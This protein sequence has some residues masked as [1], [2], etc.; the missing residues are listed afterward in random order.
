[1]IKLGQDVKVR[2]LEG[3]DFCF[4]WKIDMKGPYLANIGK[5]SCFRNKQTKIFFLLYL[6]LNFDFQNPTRPCKVKK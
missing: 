6:I 4:F 1:M 2:A 5:K 3:V